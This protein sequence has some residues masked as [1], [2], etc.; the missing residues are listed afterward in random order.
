LIGLFIANVVGV[1]CMA[2]PPEPPRELV[3]MLRHALRCPQFSNRS[4][5]APFW[6]ATVSLAMA[7]VSRRARNFTRTN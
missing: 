6:T 1:H 4:Y 7:F 3:S 2:A 5:G